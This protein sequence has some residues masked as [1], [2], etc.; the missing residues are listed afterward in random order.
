MNARTLA[1]PL[2]RLEVI[3]LCVWLCLDVGWTMMS[4]T[5]PA[6]TPSDASFTVRLGYGSHA[7]ERAYTCPLTRESK[8]R[9]GYDI[10]QRARR[11]IVHELAE[12]VYAEGATVL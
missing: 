8:A 12:A 4:T 2:S 5:K 9:H 10:A 11:A 1:E 3:S 6:F 7:I